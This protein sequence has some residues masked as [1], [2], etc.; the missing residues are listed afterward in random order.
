MPVLGTAVVPGKPKRGPDRMRTVVAKNGIGR[1]RWT[2]ALCAS[3]GHAY[4]CRRRVLLASCARYREDQLRKSRVET[5]VLN[6]TWLMKQ[7][8]GKVVPCV[9]ARVWCVTTSRRPDVPQVASRVKDRAIEQ[10]C[11]PVSVPSRSFTAEC[12]IAARVKAHASSTA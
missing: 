9:N 10:S 11:R 6:R 2:C 12:R 1:H 5:S 3:L 8:A 4:A 7:A